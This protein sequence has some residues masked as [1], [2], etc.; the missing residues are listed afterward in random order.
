MVREINGQKYTVIKEGSDVSFAYIPGGTK[1][2][3]DAARNCN[4]LVAIDHERPE[5][6]RPF[7][8]EQT[9][10]IRQLKQDLQNIQE[11][12]IKKDEEILRLNAH[13]G[14]LSGGVKKK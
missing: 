3:F 6:L 11:E 14:V 4:V 8:D 7:A 1:Q 2:I 9:I 10:I 5:D 13:I 12:L